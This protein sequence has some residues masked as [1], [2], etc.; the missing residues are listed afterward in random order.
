MHASRIAHCDLK[1]DNFLFLNEKMDSPLKIIDFGMSKHVKRRKH[2]TSLSGTLDYIAPEVLDRKYSEHCDIWSFGVIMFVMLFGYPPFYANNDE[3]IK[4]KIKKGFT[5]V[6]KKGY[7]AYFPAAIPCSDSAKDLISK[8]LCM[9]QSQ[10]LAA[11]EVCEHSFFFGGASEKPMVANV[12]ENLKEFTASVAFKV[13]V[14]NFMTDCLDKSELTLLKK[15]FKGIDENGDGHITAAELKK[16]FVKQGVADANILNKVEQLLEVADIEGDGTLSYE[17]LVLT[18]VHRKLGAKEDRLWESFC[19]F[20]QDLDGTVTETEIA[21]VL[22]KSIEEARALVAEVDKNKD[23]KIDYDEFL[24]MWMERD[25][26]MPDYS[27]CH[28]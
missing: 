19:K 24:A 27:E 21:Q 8:C 23:G 25:L 3:D 15:T 5:N 10:R 22:G 28:V 14:L 20:D 13:Q 6:T 1:P 26:R 2:F 18:S 11:R 16:A 17:E 12:L 7:G 9:D 4:R